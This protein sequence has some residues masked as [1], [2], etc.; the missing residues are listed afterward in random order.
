MNTSQLKCMIECDSVLNGRVIGVYAADR[1]PTKLPQ[2]PFG[3]I[4]NT[5]IYSKPGRH[6]CVFYSHENG[7]FDFFD[8]YGKNP[9]Q[10]SHFFQRWLENKANSVRTNHR[11][12]TQPLCGMYC[13]LFLRQRLAGFTYQDFLNTFNT[14]RYIQTIDT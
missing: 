9:S 11:V 1:L 6:W 10:N 8:S 13:I 3:F 4:A 12:I 14:L 7:H 5:D 2:S